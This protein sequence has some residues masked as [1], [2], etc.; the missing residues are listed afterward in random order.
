[1][2]DTMMYPIAQNLSN[3]GNGPLGWLIGW[4]LMIVNRR[5]NQWT[6]EVLDVHPQDHILEIG[7]GPGHAVK[8]IAQKATG[9]FVAGVDRSERMVR[10]AAR[11]N[12]AE[13]QAG[14]VELKQGGVEA[15]PYDDNSFHKAFAINVIY[16]LPDPAAAL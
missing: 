16:F 11:L 4:L 7:F 5:I 1:M 15:L 14:K 12:R 3:P 13:I 6:V 8:L 10:R 2:L 9:G